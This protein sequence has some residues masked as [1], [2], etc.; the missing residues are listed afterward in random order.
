MWHGP[1]KWHVNGLDVK[2]GDIRWLSDGDAAVRT[3]LFHLWE[4]V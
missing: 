3:R 4:A 2:H 1:S